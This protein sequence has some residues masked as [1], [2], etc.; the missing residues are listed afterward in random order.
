MLD[1]VCEDP[2]KKLYLA[3]MVSVA[4]LGESGKA[5]IFGCNGGVIRDIQTGADTPFER[6]DGIYIFKI[7]I[8]PPEAVAPDSRF[9]RHP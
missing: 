2:A 3:H 7:R 9:G 5:V 6:R 1:L 8:P 4:K